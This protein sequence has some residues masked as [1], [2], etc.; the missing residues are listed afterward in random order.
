MNENRCKLKVLSNQNEVCCRVYAV[1]NVARVPSTQDH[2]LRSVGHQLVVTVDYR[3][4]MRATDNLCS[5][6]LKC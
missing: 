4:V 5:H 3:A 1:A 6:R 2:I